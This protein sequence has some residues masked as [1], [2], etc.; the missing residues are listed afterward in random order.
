MGDVRHLALGAR[1]R[2]VKCTCRSGKP[3]TILRSTWWFVRTLPPSGLAS[4]FDAALKPMDPNL[5]GNEF[6]HTAATSGQSRFAAALC[7]ASAGGF[8]GLRCFRVARDLWRYFLFGCQRTQEIGIRMALGA[9]RTRRQGPD[10][11]SALGLAAFGL[12]IGAFASWMLT[13]AIS[14]LLFGVRPAIR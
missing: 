9:S 12:L 5:P 13:K 1:R 7:R 4:A 10:C 11:C 8:S 2:A 6:R 3:A 14:G